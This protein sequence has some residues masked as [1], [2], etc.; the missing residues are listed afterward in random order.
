MLQPKPNL[1]GLK[2]IRRE[3]EVDLKEPVPELYV[4]VDWP[5]P[6]IVA[7]DWTFYA[8]KNADQEFAAADV[9]LVNAADPLTYKIT[10]IDGTPLAAGDFVSAYA[11]ATIADSDTA[12]EP[13]NVVLGNCR[14]PDFSNVGFK[15]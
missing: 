4:D 5:Y 14:V 3:D 11:V 7:S 12:S 1:L 13:S 2:R 9:E 8:R 6:A 15:T 10:G